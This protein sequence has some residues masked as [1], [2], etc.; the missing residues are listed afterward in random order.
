MGKEAVVQEQP[1]PSRRKLTVVYLFQEFVHGPS[2]LPSHLEET[3]AAY[4]KTLQNHW[5]KTWVQ[6]LVHII[7]WFLQRCLL[8]WAGA[9]GLGKATGTGWLHF[10][11]S[12]VSQTWSSLC[13][14]KAENWVTWLLTHRHPKLL[15]G[16]L[17]A[18]VTLLQGGLLLGFVS[19]ILK[20]WSEDLPCRPLLSEPRVASGEVS[21]WWAFPEAKSWCLLMSVWC[22]LSFQKSRGEDVW[23]EIMKNV[24]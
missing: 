1:C 17:K 11:S 23:I 12:A 14:R 7:K 9:T 13:Q 2:L 5:I 24:S 6:V 4:P 22:S 20:D 8:V 10:H 21:A 3:E 15:P 16:T 18:A 19:G